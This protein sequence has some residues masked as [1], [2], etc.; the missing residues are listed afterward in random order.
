MI[1]EK[2]QF[3]KR[4]SC[5][6]IPRFALTSSEKQLSL[7][8]QLMK[9]HPDVLFHTHLSENNEEVLAISKRFP[10]SSSYLDVYDR[11]GLLGKKSSFAH[12]IHLENTDYQRLSESGSSIIHCPT[13]N[14][15]LGSGLFDMKSA[16]EKSVSICLGTD[17]G[18]G[19]S[20]SM[21]KTMAEAYKISQ[22]KGYVLSPIHSFFMATLGASIILGID[23]KI[24]NFTQGKEADF[25]V[26]NTDNIP[27]LKNRVSNSD[28][29][30]DFLFALMII[31]D[32]RIIEHS[33]IFGKDLKP[34]TLYS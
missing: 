24:G 6:I 16:T 11:F 21:L 23:D 1:I 30:E 7:A 20:F 17:V 31:G 27:L 10:R 22:I 3:R 4:S 26:I 5:A 15:F 19:T 9:E 18:A 14:M 12:G 32:D 29:L 28:S 2:W 34:T 33:F 25:I 13:S 8:S